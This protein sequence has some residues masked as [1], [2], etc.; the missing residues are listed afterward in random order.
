M[1]HTHGSQ[2]RANEIRRLVPIE[3]WRHCPGKVNPADLPSR[4][5]PMK[6]LADNSLWFNGPD[7]VT[8]DNMDTFDV[9]M[10][11]LPVEGMDELRRTKSNV[12]GDDTVGLL[13]NH[14][15][16]FISNIIF[17]DSYSSLSRLLGVT[18]TVLRFVVLMKGTSDE[19]PPSRALLY[20]KAERLWIIDAQSKFHTDKILTIW[21]SQFM[22]FQDQDGIWRCS[23][24]LGNANVPYDTK[25]PIVLPHGHPY[26]VLVMRHA[27]L[28]VLHGGTKETLSE[29]RSKY[30]VPKDRASVRRIVHQCKV[31][32]RYEAPAY[33]LPQPPP[34]PAFRVQESPPFT[35]TGVDFAGPLHIKGNSSTQKVWIAL[36]TCCVVRAVHLDVVVDL[37]TQAFIRSFK[38]FS[39]RRGLPSVM[40]S[41]NGKTF[42][43]AAKKL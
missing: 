31:C 42:K 6:G 19:T 13:V 38:R 23:G 22:L 20:K 10:V 43:G 16:D 7:W 30:W 9:S 26:T 37:S 3:C 1:L 11:E 15:D 32:Q 4:G 33:R 34:L 14:R 29:L 40:I 25:H 39:S 21:K 36:Y 8:R 12:D 27:H 24:R 35:I 17:I 5:I 41:D 18:A 28:R 2:N